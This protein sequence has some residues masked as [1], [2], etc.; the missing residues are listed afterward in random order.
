MT[1]EEWLSGLRVMSLIGLGWGLLLLLAWA[2]DR[3][4]R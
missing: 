1:G 2:T 4:S 3:L